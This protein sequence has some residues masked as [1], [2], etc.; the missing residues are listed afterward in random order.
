MRWWP[1]TIRWQMLAGL[2]LLETLSLGLFA[3]VLVHQQTQNVYLRTQKRLA[4]EVASM[5]LQAREALLQNRPG[6]VGLSVTMMGEAPTVALAKVT[7]PAGNVLFVSEG[8]PEQTTLNPAE[9]AQILL[10]RHEEARIFAVGKDQ[11]ESVK[12][13]YTG[14][15]LRGYAWVEND[16]DWDR[17]QL[18]IILHGTVIF[19]IIWVMASGLLV[20]LMAGSISR[21]LAILHRGTRALMRSPEGSGRASSSG[22]WRRRPLSRSALRAPPVEMSITTYC[23]GRIAPSRLGVMAS[24]T[25]VWATASIAGVTDVT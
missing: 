2:L 4:Y 25:P 17:E 19:G 18:L 21:P 1:R 14:S 10:V 11:W 3:L 16:R 22:S 5:T 8:E 24:T 20:L 23:P 7:D 9:R 12:A 6:W 13:I 15:D